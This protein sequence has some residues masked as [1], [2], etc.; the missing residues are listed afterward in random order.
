MRLSPAKIDYLAQKLL[1][2]MREHEGVS[3]NIDADDLERIIAWE[4]TEELR[5]EDDIDDEVNTLL[6]QYERQIAHQDLDQVLLRRKLKQE[7]A[8]KRGYTL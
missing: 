1:R 5:I 6:D 4:I 8:R 3:F 7:L 2:L